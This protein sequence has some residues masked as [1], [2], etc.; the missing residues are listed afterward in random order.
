MVGLF[1][2]S[3]QKSAELKTAALQVEPNVTPTKL[4]QDVPTRWNS[5]KEMLEVFFLSLPPSFVL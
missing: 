3:V 5:K 4:V 2:H 1:R